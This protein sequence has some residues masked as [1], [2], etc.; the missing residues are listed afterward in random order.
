MDGFSFIPYG[1]KTSVVVS[2]SNKNDETKLNRSAA[3]VSSMESQKRR[4]II[5][6]DNDNSFRYVFTKHF[7]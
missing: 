6:P 2:G 3:A 1:L 4:S 7:V 5:F